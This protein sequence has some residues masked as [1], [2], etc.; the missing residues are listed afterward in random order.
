MRRWTSFLLTLTGSRVR[1][2]HFLSIYPLPWQVRDLSYLAF[3]WAA[4]SSSKV[5]MA[6]VGR[7]LLLVSVL[8]GSATAQTITQD[9]QVVGT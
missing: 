4:V 2:S 7:F 6:V 3:D 1:Q 9:G 5:S 8:V